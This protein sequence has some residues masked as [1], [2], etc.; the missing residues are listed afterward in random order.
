MN[1][2]QP[3]PIS[4]QLKTLDIIDSSYDKRKAIDDLDQNIPY[5]VSMVIDKIAKNYSYVRE[6]GYRDAYYI[7]GAISNS[8][9]QVKVLLPTTMNSEVESWNEGETINLEAFIN[10]WD[11]AYK[12]FGLLG[13]RS[14]VSKNE[15]DSVLDAIAES[16]PD[17][18]IE[19]TDAT[20][21]TDASDALTWNTDSVADKVEPDT[22]PEGSSKQ[23]H[24]NEPA[25]Q[26]IVDEVK[27]E[28]AELESTAGPPDELVDATPANHEIEE[29]IEQMEA[30]TTLEQLAAE[31]ADA[32]PSNSD[33]A[34]STKAAIP[35]LGNV[36]TL[37]NVPTREAASIAPT[38]KRFSNHAP[39]RPTRLP[40][41]VQEDETQD[42]AKKIIKITACICVG[43]ILL[44]CLCC[45][46][47][48]QSSV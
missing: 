44:M 5:S 40:I 31:Y 46:I 36:P 33:D 6:D 12:R 35:V 2:P 42:Q 21:A 29:F 43:I 3:T 23:D 30:P 27:M 48:S 28:Q 24:A 16:T 7:T 25:E 19:M 15:V 34:I 39:V 41:E 4:D 26:P 11:L 8:K 22:Q 38:A 32:Q 37:K 9:H 17:S 14:I 10:D 18:A 1:D 13:R 47:F 20:D 45:G